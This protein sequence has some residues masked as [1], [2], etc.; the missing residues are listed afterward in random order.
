MTRIV[1]L[2]RACAIAA[3]VVVAFAGRQMSL[4]ETRVEAERSPAFRIED[5]RCI[6]TH[7]GKPVFQFVL[8]GEASDKSSRETISLERLG[9]G[10]AVRTAA[11][12]GDETIVASVDDLPFL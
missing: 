2:W 10:N 5:E 9:H 1:V 4:G 6:L 3:C 8:F 7:D 12:N 11:K